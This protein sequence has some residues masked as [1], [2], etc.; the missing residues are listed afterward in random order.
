MGV[1]TALDSM[2]A[3]DDHRTPAG[4]SIDEG[5]VCRTVPEAGAESTPGGVGC[6][7]GELIDAGDV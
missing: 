3:G 4:E 2:A 6:V 7:T 5:M 1:L